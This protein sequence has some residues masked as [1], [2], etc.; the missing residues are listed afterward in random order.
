LLT[1]EIAELCNIN[2]N[3]TL[4]QE[5][6]V[7]LEKVKQNRPEIS[8]LIDGGLELFLEKVAI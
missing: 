8:H 2:K 6:L 7:Y 4:L 1:L 3:T 5:V